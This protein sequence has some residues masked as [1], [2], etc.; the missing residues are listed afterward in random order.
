MKTLVLIVISC[1]AFGTME[2]NAA[3]C[4]GCVK[5]KCCA[6]TCGCTVVATPACVTSNCCKV[7]TKAFCAVAKCCKTKYYKVKT[8]TTACGAKTK[9]RKVKCIKSCC[10]SKCDC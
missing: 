9:C 1:L 8:K 4:C 5:Q 2:V 6:T 3:T 10:C 7:T